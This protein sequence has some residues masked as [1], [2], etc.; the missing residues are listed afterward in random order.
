MLYD[1]ILFGQNKSLQE[2]RLHQTRRDRVGCLEM[3]KILM[4]SPKMASSYHVKQEKLIQS[5]LPLTL[6]FPC[7]H[8]SLSKVATAAVSIAVSESTFKKFIYF[9]KFTLNQYLP[10]E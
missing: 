3:H 5:Y 7:V 1:L 8:S 2:V 9:L 4:Q 10:E 6:G